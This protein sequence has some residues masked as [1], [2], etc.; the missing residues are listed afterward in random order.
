MPP[1]PWVEGQVMSL[2]GV[3]VITVVWTVTVPE[4]EGLILYNYALVY[5]HSAIDVLQRKERLLR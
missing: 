3:A 2:G 1:S 4:G 5:V